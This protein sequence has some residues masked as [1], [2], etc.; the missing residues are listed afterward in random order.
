MPSRDAT[1]SL[2]LALLVVALMQVGCD[3]G[4]ES[5]TTQGTS[6][7]QT[8]VTGAGELSAL[9][10]ALASEYRVVVLPARRLPRKE[11][12]VPPP[13]RDAVPA[14]VEAV[15]GLRVDLRGRR[16]GR[17]Y[18]YASH[19]MAIAAAPSFLRRGLSGEVSGCSAQIWFTRSREV[20]HRSTRRASPRSLSAVADW[21]ASVDRA[22]SR[23]DPACRK[24]RFG[25]IA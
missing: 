23:T 25:V 7:R 20:P 14:V 10:K 13:R 22:L 17:V 18:R 2:P 6:A 1:R 21:E 8:K 16:D 24:Q 9:A 3:S 19:E 12:L 15:A 11:P 4:T 5:T